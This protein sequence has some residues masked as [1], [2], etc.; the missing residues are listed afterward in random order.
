MVHTEDSYGSGKVRVHEESNSGTRGVDLSPPRALDGAE[1]FFVGRGY[2]VVQRT[3]TTLT[4][5]REGSEGPAG[6][7]VTPKVVVMAVPQPDGATR[8]R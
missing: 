8:R 4:V 5:E 3:D 2:A 7:E 6:E 1:S